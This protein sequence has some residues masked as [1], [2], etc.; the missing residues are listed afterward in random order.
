MSYRVATIEELQDI[1]YRQDT[2]MRPVRHHLGITAF[3]TNAWTAAN[4]GDRLMPEHQEDEGNEELYVVLRGR[5]RFEIDGETV[6]APEGTLVF[7]RP[8]GNRTAFAEE[9][10]TTVIA[11]GSKVGQPYEAGGW[12]VWAEFHPAYEAG[13]YGAVIDRARKTLEASGYATPLYNLACCESLAGHKQDAIGH[14]RVAFERRPS[15]RDMAN[16]DTDLDPLRDEP[17]FRELVG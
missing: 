1:A 17:A 5:A 8:E 4:E 16:E 3:G 6:D 7:V 9:A 14:L 12:E 13:D 10:E 2:H 11:I 15:L